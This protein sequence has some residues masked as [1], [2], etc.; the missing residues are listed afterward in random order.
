MNR[1]R[2]YAAT[3]AITMLIGITAALAS[4]ASPASA[5]PT[6]T[7]IGD[8]GNNTF[9]HATNLNNRVTMRPPSFTSHQLWN[10]T[11]FS[12]GYY[13][14]TSQLTDGCLTVDQTSSAFNPPVIQRACRG[15]AYERWQLVRT[16]TTHYMFHNVG[17]QGRCI[18]VDRSFDPPRLR[19]YPCDRYARNQ[20]FTVRVA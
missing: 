4:P 16:S 20:Q 13:R 7:R 3:A 11:R 10:Y 19:A 6:Y 1:Y 8:Y 17:L 9:A 5:D 15:T 14:F 2:R 12:T 18:G